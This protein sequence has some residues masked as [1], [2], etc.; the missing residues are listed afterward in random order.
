MNI[1]RVIAT[2]VD[3][4]CRGAT[5]SGSSNTSANLLLFISTTLQYEAEE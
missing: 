3:F 1:V 2:R 5:E 4:V